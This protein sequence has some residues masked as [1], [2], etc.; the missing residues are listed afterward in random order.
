LQPVIDWFSYDLGGF[1]TF[2]QTST[3]V[4]DGW[5]AGDLLNPAFADS[6]CDQANG[7]TPLACELR[8]AQASVIFISVGYYDVQN[9]TDLNEFREQVRR[10]VETSVNYGT[11][12]VLLTIRPGADAARTAELNQVIID[13]ASSYSA[14]LLNAFG[15]LAALPDPTI[16]ASPSGPGDLSDFSTSSYGLNALNRAALR[17]LQALYTQIFPDAAQP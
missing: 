3:A 9:F 1:N 7:E 14:P 11:I 10:I 17:T 2:A 15:A 16:A 5:R 6:S 12:P 4:Q 8:M 13:V